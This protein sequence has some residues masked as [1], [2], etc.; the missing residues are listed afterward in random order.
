MFNIRITHINAIVIIAF[1]ILIILMIKW[2]GLMINISNSMPEG[3]YYSHPYNDHLDNLN[4]GDIV[5]VCLKE[6]F[7][8]IGLQRNYID[9][10]QK[11]HG[12]IPLIKSVF[13]LPGDK[14]VLQAN[15]IIVNGNTYS[16]QTYLKDRLG[17]PLDAITRGTYRSNGYWLIGTHDP[18]SWD[19][20][21]WGEIQP[22]QIVAI[23]KPAITW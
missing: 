15:Q 6:P 23:L 9:P 16:Y 4:K 18:H 10:G 14:I 2:M 21:Y 22:N 7:L 17:R 1:L 13:A 5:A 12:S 20:R 11:C 3:L 8:D 19:S